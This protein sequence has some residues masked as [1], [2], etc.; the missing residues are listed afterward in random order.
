MKY[1]MSAVNTWSKCFKMHC[2]ILYRISILFSPQF[3][4]RASSS[5]LLILV[6]ISAL[7]FSAA[8]LSYSAAVPVCAS[9]SFNPGKW[10]VQELFQRKFKS[11]SFERCSIFLAVGAWYGHIYRSTGRA[12]FYTFSCLKANP[13]NWLAE[14]ENTA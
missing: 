9:K 14:D 2:R 8:A 5:K 12:F 7:Y 6:S 13:S 10:I 3:G 4:S 11:R 1:E